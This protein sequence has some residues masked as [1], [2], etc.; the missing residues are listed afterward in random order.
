MKRILFLFICPLLAVACN[1]RVV[2]DY[3]VIPQ[4]QNLSVKDGDVYV[5]DSSRKLVY[6][7][8]DS[9]RSLELFAQDLEELVGIRP[10]VA[11]GTSEDAKGN[12]YFT[13]GLQDGRKEAYSINVSSDGILVQAVAPEGIYRAT[14]TLLKSVGTEKTSSV[15]FPSAEVSDWPRFGYRGLMLDV[16]RHFSDVEMVK[17]TIDMLALHQLNMFHWHLTDDQG[18]RIEIKSHPELTE[19]GA[20]RDD[21]V[22]GRYLG[23]MDY[24]TDG[25]RH[26]GFYTQ[27]QI[28]EIVAYAKERYIEIIPEIDLPGHTSAVL[29]AYPQL[30]CEDKE[31]KV[32]N[33]WGVIRDVLCAGNP[34]SL[35]L[36]KDI[37][38]EVCE[39]FPGKYIHLGGDECVKERW[40]AC[41]KCQRKI[42][43]LGLKDG[44]RYS[45]EDY[46]QSWFMGEVA[47]FVQSKGKRVIGW[48]EILEGVPMDDSVIMSWR[49]TEG[50]ITAARMGHDVVMTPTSD[51]YF[52]QSQ[53]LASQLEEIPVGG[54]INVMK[55]YSYEPLPASLT[56]EQQKHILGC[57]ANVWCEYMPEERIRQY[58]MLPRLAALSE[59]Q[60]TMPERKNYKDFLKRLPKMLSIYDHYGYNYAK[61]IF[62][63]ACSYSV[64]VEKGSLEVFLSTLGNDPIY[65]TLDGT[66]PQT[67]K[68]MLYDDTP[69]VISSP[70]ELKVSVL[71]NGKFTKEETLFKLDCNKATFKKVNIS[72]TLNIMQAH[73]PHEILTDGI[74]GSLRCDDYRWMSCTGRMSLVLDLGKSESFSR[75]GW[76]ALNSQSENILVP[77]NVKVQISEDGK[78]YC[79]I[80]DIEKNHE[81]QAQQSVEYISEEV[82]EQAARYIK[83]D[84]YSYKY[85]DKSSPSWVFLSEL[86]VE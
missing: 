68:A 7:N 11:A 82:G 17:R 6:D 35:N 16:S 20:W 44:S 2:A 33:R 58:Q 85:P 51:M 77:Q 12:V 84:F 10:S 61:H 47:S 46:L 75:I 63:V 73:L 54:F 5:F 28:R 56:P 22:V 53:T 13:L 15:E 76:T 79:T 50:G 65:Y 83:M 1:K 86:T 74:V 80:L 40:K 60:W 52:D 34:A 4:V 21:T 45:K 18:W 71:R 3:N 14:R 66:S 29:A 27:E 72:T 26:G 67:K 78:Q 69:I 30:G 25:K 32:A 42:R 59:V 39:L 8:Q 9:R 70:S 64:N 49:G 48:D 41:P 57:Q 31:Y 55:V 36:F 24:P 38:N 43:E 62:D 37:M 23:G 81:I 19:V